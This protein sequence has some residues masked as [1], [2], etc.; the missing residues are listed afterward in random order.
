MKVDNI[1]DFLSNHKIKKINIGQSGADIYLVDNKYVLKHTVNNKLKN[2]ELFLTFRKEAQLYDSI[3]K[4][5]L[6]CLPEVLYIKENDDEIILLMKSYRIIKHIDV[7]GDILNKIIKSIAMVH[8]CRVPD[9]LLQS[10]KD[11]SI[12]SDEQIKNYV[13]GW[14]SILNEHKGSFDDKPLEEIALII[15]P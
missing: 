1:E 14:K 11:V 5:E 13:T 12:L 8:Q 6:Q 15:T 9:F 4:N 3:S 7:K 2:R 10:K